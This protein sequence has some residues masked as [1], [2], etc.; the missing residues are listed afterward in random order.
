MKYNL[1]RMPGTYEFDREQFGFSINSKIYN[2]REYSSITDCFRIIDIKKK[3]KYI[4]AMDVIENGKMHSDKDNKY[5]Y[6]CADYMVDAPLY[7][8]TTIKLYKA[9]QNFISLMTKLVM[10]KMIIAYLKKENDVEVVESLTNKKQFKTTFVIKNVDAF[11][12][13][14]DYFYDW[15]VNKTCSYEDFLNKNISKIGKT[16]YLMSSTDKYKIDPNHPIKFTN[17]QDD[18]DC[19]DTY[20][21]YLNLF[22]RIKQIWQKIEFAEQEHNKKFNAAVIWT[23]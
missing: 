21:A 16:N 17:V 15:Y 8:D 5:F 9:N 14:Y 3:D 18:L 2:A 20:V 11:K 19:A 10:R 1:S 12:N 4:E 13:L 6:K 7:Y 22:N 23:V